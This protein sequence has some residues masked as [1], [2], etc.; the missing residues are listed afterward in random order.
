LTESNSKNQIELKHLNEYVKNFIDYMEK[1]KNSENTNFASKR[2]LELHRDVCEVCNKSRIDCSFNPHCENRMYLS[3]QIDLDY[4][5]S[6]LPDFCYSQHLW[7]LSNFLNG[8]TYSIE[9]IDVKLF[10]ED[11]MKILEINL[12]VEPKA[13]NDICNEIVKKMTK[14]K[15]RVNF[16]SRIEG[17][18][19]YFLFISDGII[20]SIDLKKEIVTIN[21]LNKVLQE[22]QEFADII[23]LLGQFYNFKVEIIEEIA[24][25]WYLKIAVPAKK[26]KN[27]NIIKEINEKLQEFLEYTQFFEKD[28]IINFII[29]L[30]TPSNE[31]WKNMKF[32]IAKI[33]RIFELLFDLSKKIA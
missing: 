24:G 23:N 13:Y 25:W 21:V 16:T 6:E 29:D 10:L 26:L 17:T 20:Y 19:P 18:I 14:L 33:K 1:S 7:N 11:F 8:K 15:G 3:M 27:I 32:S 9:P 12:K 5:K 28:N 22:E 30:K 31:N 2:F 4:K